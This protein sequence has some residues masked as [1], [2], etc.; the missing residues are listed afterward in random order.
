M[1]NISYEY[2]E[3]SEK[4]KSWLTSE[5]VFAGRYITSV[6]KAEEALGNSSHTMKTPVWSFLLLYNNNKNNGKHL[7]NVY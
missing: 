4:I 2:L 7:L 5:T 6:L 3:D 1:P